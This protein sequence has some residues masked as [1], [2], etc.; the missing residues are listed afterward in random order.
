MLRLLRKVVDVKADLPEGR[1]HLLSLR[2]G[3]GFVARE[4]E[5]SPDRLQKPGRN[6]ID[7]LVATGAPSLEG[8]KKILVAKLVD[9]DRQV[10]IPPQALVLGAGEVVTSLEGSKELDRQWRQQLDRPHHG[11]ER[12]APRPRAPFGSTLAVG[13]TSDALTNL[14]SELLHPGSGR[15]LIGVLAKLRDQPRQE[16]L[17]VVVALG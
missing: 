11:I 9:G 1:S 6:P 10:R 17:E 12:P 16:A 14:S 15:D 8:H 13:G 5:S 2:L 4:D 3:G 7:G